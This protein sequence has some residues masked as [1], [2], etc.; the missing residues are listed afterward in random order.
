MYSKRIIALS[1]LCSGD[2]D[3]ADIGADHGFLSILLAKKYPNKNILA[4]ENKKGPYE[5]LLNNIINE[6]LIN[7]SNIKTSFSD[8][9]DKVDN[10]YKCIILA[11]MGFLNIKNIILKNIKKISFIDEFIVDCH[12]NFF[13]LIEFMKELNY[14][15]FK[16]QILE[17]LNI[18]YF[19]IKFKKDY[20]NVNFFEQIS[21]Y[22]L[23]L[24]LKKYNNLSNVIKEV[25]NYTSFNN[26]LLE[27][28]YIKK[29]NN[30]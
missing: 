2:Y 10:G 17:E 4:I 26:S 20:S 22:D 21:N 11:G 28:L 29:V 27:Y 23:K 9:L 19:L 8:G 3:M 12:T 6:G 7:N 1:N 25:K 16:I 13:E 15:I 18:I 24:L 5:N 14:S 30:L